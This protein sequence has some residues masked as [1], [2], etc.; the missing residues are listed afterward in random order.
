MN[1]NKVTGH[2]A[3]T[4]PRKR[5]HSRM[6]LGAQVTESMMGHRAEEEGRGKMEAKGT[7]SR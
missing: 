3:W 2:R 6:W 5:G 1:N 7:D 4:R